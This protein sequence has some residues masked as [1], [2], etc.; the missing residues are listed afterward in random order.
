MTST[1]DTQDGGL[2]GQ[3]SFPLNLTAREGRLY[4]T[5]TSVDAAHPSTGYPIASCGDSINGFLRVILGDNGKIFTWDGST[6]TERADSTGTYVE[7]ISDIIQYRDVT[8]AT[9]QTN[10]H[11]FTGATF[12]TI[13]ETWGS[14]GFGVSLDSGYPHPQLVFENNYWVASKNTLHRWD[15]TT[16][17]AGFLTL[18][19]GQV[20]VALAIDPQS[21]KMLISITEG[22]N[23]NGTLSMVAKVAV[24]DGYSN[25][26]TRVP[27]VDDMVTAFHPI[28]G[29]VYVA[30]GT[31]IGYW[32]GSGISFLRKTKNV[33]LTSTSLIYKHHITNIGKTLYYIDGA[34]VMAYGEIKRGK[35]VFYPAG[36]IST[37][38]TMHMICHVGS[39]KLGLGS[40]STGTPVFHTQDLST[41]DATSGTLNFYSK[42]YRFK[43]KVN[44]RDIRV[45]FN[46]SVAAGVKVA[47]VVL[48]DQNGTV[49]FEALQNGGTVASYELT[50]LA[51]NND[52]PSSYFQFQ[53]QGVQNINPG[54][55]A[56]IVSYDYVK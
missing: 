22:L 29:V 56:I 48:T 27:I 18:P 28:G 4:G 20:I 17:S 1:N 8:L 23:L 50:S 46:D 52:V 11:K 39:E 36:A 6:M 47:D 38:A 7:G 10:V 53:F 34:V 51:Q 32:N 19:A 37:G 14:V 25:K 13:D 43:N 5:A 44:V 12:G 3:S 54:I 30:Y 9:S 31:S 24:Y 16:F 42:K 21:G 40:G 26:P 41:I 15:G 49:N 35:R 45:V 2:S 55:E 33:T